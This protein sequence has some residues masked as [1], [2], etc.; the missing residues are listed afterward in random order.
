MGGV[1][2]LI[3][4][5]VFVAFD[6]DVFRFVHVGHHL[7][8]NLSNAPYPRVII[9]NTL[10][11]SSLPF[12][13]P[14][15]LPLLS[16]SLCSGVPCLASV[17]LC[18]LRKHEQLLHGKIEAEFDTLIT[19]WWRY[20]RGCGSLRCF[21]WVSDWTSW[22]SLEEGHSEGHVSTGDTYMWGN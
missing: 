14:L 22:G 18:S 9:R 17:P 10:P 8:D 3:L 13:H 20:M 12:T 11:I 4:K 16:V 7:N 15:H 1:L 6:E 2:L 19:F 21:C 5:R